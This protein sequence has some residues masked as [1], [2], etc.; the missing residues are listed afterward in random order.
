MRNLSAVVC[1]KFRL[2]SGPGRSQN[3]VRVSRDLQMPTVSILYQLFSSSAYYTVYS[4]YLESSSSLPLPAVFSTPIRRRFPLMSY[5][6]YRL[7][8]PDITSESLYML[9]GSREPCNVLKLS[10]LSCHAPCNAT[11]LGKRIRSPALPLHG[12]HARRPFVRS[13]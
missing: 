10:T 5:N 2:I 6:E 9:K 8:N 13:M 11:R 12:M 4:I 3:V 7:Y 1:K